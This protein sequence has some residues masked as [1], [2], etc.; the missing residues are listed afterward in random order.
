[1]RDPRFSELVA[2]WLRDR[3][4]SKWQARIVS[5]DG[6]GWEPVDDRT[7]R[8]VGTPGMG[9]IAAHMARGLDIQ[10][11]TR[12]ESLDMLKEF[13]RIIVA[14]PPA[15]AKP[16]LAEAPELAGRVASINMQPCWAVMAAFEER[17]AS[18]FDAAFVAGSPL[19][20]IKRQ[21]R[22]PREEFDTWVLHATSAWSRAH[23][24]DQAD[25]VAP[26]LLEAFDDLVR[27][28]LPRVFHFAGHRWKYALADPGLSVGAMH[29]DSGRITVCGDWSDRIEDAY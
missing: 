6:E 13:D 2:Y 15:Q 14:V 23:I 1:M 3:V 7:D 11:G 25:V 17:V 28:G 12:I 20:W 18:R 24:D 16:L 5:F 4:V 8:Y 29:D 19:G 26:F 10:Y 21:Q 9:T 22:N 27:G